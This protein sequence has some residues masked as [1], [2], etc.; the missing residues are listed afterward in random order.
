MTR[1]ATKP[2]L[3]DEARRLCGWLHRYAR[4]RG[5]AVP[6]RRLA[7]LMGVEVRAIYELV[8]ELQLA[9]RPVGSTPRRPRPGA[10]I[11][12]TDEDWEAAEANLKR[13]LY[14]PLRRL[15]RLRMARR[16]LRQGQATMALAEAPAE[17]PP[18]TDARGQGLLLNPSGYEEV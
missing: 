18:P 11:C 15:R 12:E 3:S 4:G 10:Y 9:G 1:D 17:A 8:A 14:R 13:R 2:A 6:Y 7:T 5:R 16:E